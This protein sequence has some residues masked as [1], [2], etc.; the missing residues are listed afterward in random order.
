MCQGSRLLQEG[1]LNYQY[2]KNECGFYKVVENPSIKP[3]L[4][5]NQNKTI[6]S[7]DGSGE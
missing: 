4:E 3:C 6:V 1:N 5:K 2:M 7:M